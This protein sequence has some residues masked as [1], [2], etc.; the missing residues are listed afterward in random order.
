[1]FRVVRSDNSEIFF[2]ISDTVKSHVIAANVRR[3]A[4]I[5]ENLCNTYLQRP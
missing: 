3:H 5:R 1:M 2:D 4:Q